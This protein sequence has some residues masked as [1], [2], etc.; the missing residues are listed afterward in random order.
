VSSVQNNG[1][2]TTG[3]ITGARFVPGRSG[4]P[5]GRPRGLVRITRELVADDGRP[6]AEFWLAT[7]ND[8]GAKLS[9]RLEASRLLADRGWGKA[10]KGEPTA[11][12]LAPTRYTTLEEVDR[13]IELLCRASE[14]GSAGV[15]DT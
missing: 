2:S 12:E 5:S 3:G 7:M 13:E 4:N 11:E 6:I 1:G 15:L 14:P 8:P 10:D 9:E